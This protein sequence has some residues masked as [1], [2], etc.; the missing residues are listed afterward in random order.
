MRL[1]RFLVRFLRALRKRTAT[2][3]T[4]FLIGGIVLLVVSLGAGVL[5]VTRDQGE[6]KSAVVETKK[7]ATQG[8]ATQLGAA[9]QAAA[10]DDASTTASTPKST[11]TKPAPAKTSTITF[12]LSTDAVTVTA[13]GAS[14][15]VTARTTDGKAV[16]W[17][18]ISP[19]PNV[20]TKTGASTGSTMVASHSFTFGADT[21]SKPGKYVAT[22]RAWVQKGPTADKTITVTVLPR[23]TFSL[24]GYPYDGVNDVSA[25]TAETA[26]NCVPFSIDWLISGPKPQLNMSASIISAPDPSMQIVGVFPHSDYGCVDLF[27]SIAPGTLVIRLNGSDGTY[28]TS[29]TLTYEIYD[30]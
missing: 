30:E 15:T 29:A 13:G 2:I 18:I 22:V 14:P 19:G 20:F 25:E 11:A 23:V 8:A 6:Q 17:V 24:S 27:G 9:I 1:Y 3:P 16:S 12:S 21:T 28:S 7:T 4:Y 5:F 10:A 26:E